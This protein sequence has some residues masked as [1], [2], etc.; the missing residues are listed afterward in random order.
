MPARK[1]RASAKVKSE[2][3]PAKRH[4]SFPVSSRNTPSP[5]ATRSSQREKKAISHVQPSSED[6]EAMEVAQMEL[7]DALDDEDERMQA[8]VNSPSELEPMEV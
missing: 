5:R 8:D 3:V 6:L 1:K 4:K 7:M 2:E